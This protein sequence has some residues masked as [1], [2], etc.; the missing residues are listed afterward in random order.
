MGL[1][2]SI[3]DLDSDKT[4]T[5][6]DPSMVYVGDALEAFYGLLITSG[7]QPES[8]KECM[9]AFLVVRGYFND[10]K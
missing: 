6:E 9:H 3:T 5:H 4:S 10:D 1:K 8:I 2:I 7:F